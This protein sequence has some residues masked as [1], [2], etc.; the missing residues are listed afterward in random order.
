MKKSLNFV[1][2][3]FLFLSIIGKNNV[4]AKEYDWHLVKNPTSKKPQIYGSYAA[5][6][7]DGA[8]K[9]AEHGLG[10]INN[11]NKDSDLIKNSIAR[12]YGQ[13]E[14]VRY[15]KNLAETI[16][17]DLGKNIVIG[18]LSSP[19]GGPM[20]ITS[21]L[22]QSHQTGL[23]VDIWYK[24]AVHGQKP[25]KIKQI[26]MVSGDNVNKHQGFWGAEQEI[27]LQQAAK[28]N[29]VD[30]IFVNYVIKQELCH[31]YSG[32]N[33][34]GK[35]RPWWGHKSH[36]HVRLKCPSSSKDCINQKPLD[37]G[38]G[39]DDELKWWFSDE[40]RPENM[41]KEERK[42]PLLPKQCDLVFN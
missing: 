15:I 14:L 12:S 1:T 19:R 13:P 21:S 22:H 9:L 7:M 4:F 30:R 39:C 3:F 6:C 36:F 42:Y 33:W 34:L 25:N 24:T 31:K 18:D 29:E 32:E 37:A 17:N 8:V 38:D 10:F 16:H 26:S 41:K 27:M 11:S 23:D 40:A 2:Y 35:I 28:F 5:G 20:P